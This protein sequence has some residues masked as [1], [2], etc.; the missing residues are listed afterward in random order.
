MTSVP[1]PVVVLIVYFVTALIF[2]RSYICILGDI[3]V[4]WTAPYFVPGGPEDK[5]SSGKN[6]M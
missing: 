6:H 5:G 4:T 2:N 3:I 1:F